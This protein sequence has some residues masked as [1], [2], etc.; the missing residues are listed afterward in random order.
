[1][2]TLFKNGHACIIGVGGDLPN[3]INDAQGLADIFKDTKRCAYPPKQVHLLTGKK[4]K[5]EDIL[6]TLDNLAQTTNS[7]STVVIYFSGHGYEATSTMGKSYYLMPFAYDCES[8]Y[9][10]AISGAEFTQKLQAIPTKKL[11]ILLDCCHAGG[12]DNI[13]GL[14]MEKSPLPPEAQTLF[15]QGKGIVLIASSK[16]DEQSYTGKPY[17]AFT[18]AVIEALAG[19]GVA[20]KDGYVRVSDIALHTREVVPKR[21]HDKQHPIL[22]WREGDNFRLAYYAGGE[23]EPKE[24]PFDEI[25]EIEYQTEEFN[26]TINNTIIVGKQES[27][28]IININ[29]ARDLHFGDIININ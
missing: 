16:K 2:N 27:E 4:A 6:S 3:T 20:E 21:T 14:T 13:E 12:L 18:L 26:S 25:P 19:K 28:N 24:L 7:E 1:M 11:L 15:N 5:Q 8:L 17:S 29:Q 23:L 22:N 10:T 9:Q